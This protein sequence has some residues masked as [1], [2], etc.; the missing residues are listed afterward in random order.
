MGSLGITGK[1]TAKNTG[2][3]CTHRGREDRARYGVEITRFIHAVVWGIITQLC[4]DY[5]A[6]AVS[7][8]SMQRLTTR[9]KCIPNKEAT[10]ARELEVLG[11]YVVIFQTY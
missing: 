4:G 9:W 11:V 1:N 10:P 7:C 3:G 8:T 5:T 2:E 6:G